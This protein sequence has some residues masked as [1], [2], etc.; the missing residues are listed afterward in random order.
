LAL[1]EPGPLTLAKRMTKSLT[2]VSGML[3]LRE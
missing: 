1:A 3:G 2:A